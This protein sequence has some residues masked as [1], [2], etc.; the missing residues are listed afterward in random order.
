MK[1]LYSNELTKEMQKLAAKNVPMKVAIAYWGKGALD[2]LGLNPEKANLEV[3]CC[4]K[5][6]KSDPDVIRQFG[7]KARQ[8][9]NLHA[10]VIWTPDEAIVGSANASSNGLPNEERLAPGLEEAGVLLNSRQEIDAIRE[11][12]DKL[13]NNLDKVR[14]I[15][16]TDLRNARKERARGAYGVPVELVTMSRDQIKHLKLAIF[17]WAY[18]ASDEEQRQVEKLNEQRFNMEG[19]D[20]Y[21]TSRKNAKHFPYGY[22]TLTY[23]VDPVRN[24]VL[25]KDG[26]QYFPEQN[27]W[28][29]IRSD[30]KP[31][32]VI[33]AMYTKHP[34]HRRFIIGKQSEAEIRARLIGARVRLGHSLAH[35]RLEDGFMSWEPLE[36][37]LKRPLSQ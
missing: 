6:G 30:G 33:F 5:G 26:L 17:L 4:L 19:A 35:R 1:F 27:K 31:T 25:G 10:K 22:Y 29:E 34:E 23:Q 3:I 21:I 28:S 24:K 18:E 9:D 32:P 16:D 8:M 36:E 37:F 12:F 20:W 11:W 2:L 7:D 13:Y 15:T 14:S